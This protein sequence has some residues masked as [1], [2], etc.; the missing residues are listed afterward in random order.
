MSVKLI[1]ASVLMVPLFSITQS[2]NCKPEH[3]MRYESGEW[4]YLI[5][6]Y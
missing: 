2:K 6:D 1:F 3:E 4:K 5:L